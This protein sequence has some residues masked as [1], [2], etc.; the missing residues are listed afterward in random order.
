V[1][2]QMRQGENSVSG[3]PKKSQQT[4]KYEQHDFRVPEDGA[5]IGS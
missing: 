1:S 2:R 4:N 5:I 3:K